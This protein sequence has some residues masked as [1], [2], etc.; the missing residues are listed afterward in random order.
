[1]TQIS[2]NKDWYQ[3]SSFFIFNEVKNLYNQGTEFSVRAIPPPVQ[4]CLKGPL[5]YLLMPLLGKNQLAI[6][7]HMYASIGPNLDNTHRGQI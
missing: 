6:T 7:L 1:M 4:C 5:K 2:D 3:R